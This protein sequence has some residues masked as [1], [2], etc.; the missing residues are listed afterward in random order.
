MTQA[1]RGSEKEKKI[2]AAKAALAKTPLPSYIEVL[3]LIKQSEP[4]PGQ[5]L[6]ELIG[7]HGKK[8]WVMVVRRRRPHNPL[9]VYSAK[10]S[11]PPS[12]T[13]PTV[14]DARKHA[15]EWLFRRYQNIEW[16]MRRGMSP[17]GKGDD[18]KNKEK[19]SGE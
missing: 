16:R 2:K 10:D 18:S 3:D 19:E 6:Y 1:L 4:S 9:I 8:M 14:V 17:T 5:F 12:E 15:L 7:P 13:I 11:D